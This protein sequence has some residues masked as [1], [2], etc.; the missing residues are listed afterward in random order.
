MK[1]IFIVTLLSLLVASCAMPKPEQ[2]S[3]ERIGNLTVRAIDLTGLD[4]SF[5][6][7]VK[8]DY[9]RSITINAADVDLYAGETVLANI[10]L[11][12]DVIFV[13]DAVTD[14]DAQLRL[15]MGR[16]TLSELLVLA[17]AG[18]STRFSIKGTV[19]VRIGAISK[20]LDINYKIPERYNRQIMDQ[21]KNKMSLGS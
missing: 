11:R 20:K 9:S 7:A 13:R 18:N 17:A 19:K 8:S 4:I 16:L 6:G 12:E 10:Q 2:F 15:R 3:I 21:I 14:I 5:S 1:K